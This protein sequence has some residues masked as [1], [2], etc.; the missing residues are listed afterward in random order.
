[1][2][3]EKS[4]KKALKKRALGYDSTEV[5]EEY[6]EDGDGGVRLIKRKV[7]SKNVPPDVS[8]AK[9]LIELDGDSGDLSKL[10]DEELESE[11]QRL[12]KLFLK[13]N[14]DNKKK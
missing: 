2:E 12:I 8:A 3:N 7:V 14:Y 1:M 4:I 11:K 6:Q 13:E 5:T 10:T 9:L